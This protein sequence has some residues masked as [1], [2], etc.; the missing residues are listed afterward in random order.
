[1]AMVVALPQKQQ[2]ESTRPPQPT[3]FW[4]PKNQLTTAAV[5]F[6]EKRGLP[7]TMAAVASDALP[8]KQKTNQ[9]GGAGVR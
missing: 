9:P 8:Q 5:V 3:C 7:R 1:M 2:I 4:V 6:L